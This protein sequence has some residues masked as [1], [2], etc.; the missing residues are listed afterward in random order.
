MEED[1]TLPLDAMNHVVDEKDEG[2]AEHRAS[3]ETGE[4]FLSFAR[5][6]VTRLGGERAAASSQ[7]HSSPKSMDK[8][9]IIVDAL[10]PNRCSYPGVDLSTAEII[11]RHEASLEDRELTPMLCDVKDA[12]HR[13]RVRDWLALLFGSGPASS[14]ELCQVLSGA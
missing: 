6:L 1:K 4:H 10:C 7:L 8:S 2:L 3:H 5:R 11:W 13:F 9:R 14:L 12:F